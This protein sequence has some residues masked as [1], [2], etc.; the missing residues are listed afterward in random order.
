MPSA[1]PVD[2][3]Y[4]RDAA[5]HRGQAHRRCDCHEA[6]PLAG[7]LGRLC[8]HPCE[9]GC[10]RGNWDSPAAIRDM[11]RFVTDQDFKQTEPHA[12]SRKPSTGNSVAIIGAG[13]AGL[14]AA[15]YLSRE[16]HS[17]TVADLGKRKRAEHCVTW[18][19]TSCPVRCW[20]P[21]STC[22]R[23]WALISNSAWNLASRSRWK[24]SGAGLVPV[25]V[26]VGELAKE[27]G[28]VWVCHWQEI[29]SK[30]TQTHAR[31]RWRKFSPPA[32][33]CDSRSNW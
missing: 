22:S 26:T 12:P 32:A 2:A 31:R 5:T 33:R 27:D 6:L 13:P 20:P 16:G 23:G 11:E 10:R 1:V 19:R 21:R 8:H 4:P 25:L 18:R 29:Q 9:Q 30:R 17:V 7:V 24:G 3:E 14:A 28:G 15:Y